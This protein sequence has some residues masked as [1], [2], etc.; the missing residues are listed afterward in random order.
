MENKLSK[1]K[2]GFR[3]LHGT[4]NSMV[5]MLCNWRKAQDKTEYICVFIYGSIKGL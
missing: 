1:S 5:T 4:Q 2:I 3:K